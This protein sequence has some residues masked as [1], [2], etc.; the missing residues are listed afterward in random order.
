MNESHEREGGVAKRVLASTVAIKNTRTQEHGRSRTRL[1]PTQT[2][3]LVWRWGTAPVTFG[4][5]LPFGNLISC[6]IFRA[7]GSGR[8]GCWNFSISSFF[9]VYVFLTWLPACLPSLSSP[10]PMDTV[11][12]L[13][14]AEFRD[15]GKPF[16][17]AGAPFHLNR[18]K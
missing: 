13:V 9:F 6:V 14:R 1:D 3:D 4:T 15:F 11:P 18:D 17:A 5:L 2:R 12:W 8:V 16:S 10:L 7:V